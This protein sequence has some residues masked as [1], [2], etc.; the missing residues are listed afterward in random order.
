MTNPPEA[1]LCKGTTRHKRENPQK[2][3]KEECVM[4]GRHTM[5]IGFSSKTFRTESA[6]IDGPNPGL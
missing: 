2:L 6:A 5:C 4:S 3:P 1:V